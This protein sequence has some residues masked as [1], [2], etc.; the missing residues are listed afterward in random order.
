ML[1]REALFLLNNLFFMSILVDM[2]L[3]C[4]LPAG[5]GII[6]RTKSDRRSAIL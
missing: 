1:S 3:G 5:F 2:F 4:D 6:H